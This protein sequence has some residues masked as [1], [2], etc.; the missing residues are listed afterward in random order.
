MPPQPAPWAPNGTG[1]D[2]PPRIGMS[3]AFRQ[4]RV[5]LGALRR[6]PYRSACF[7]LAFGVVAV[8]ALNMVAQVRL[9]TWQG[10]FYNA[11]DQR[12]ASELL[13]QTLIFL[14]IVAGLLLLVVGETFF[15][16]LLI[17]RLR[18]WLTRD[19]LD[20]WV[21]GR[22]P[23]LLSFRGDIAQNPDQRLQADAR[24]L[25]ELSIGLAIGLLRSSLLLVGFL[26]VLWTLSADTTFHLDGRE[27]RIPG[28]LVWCALAYAIGGSWL[29][30]RVGRPMIGLNAERY[31]REAELRFALVRVSENAEAIALD[32]GAPDER[33]FL[34]R[35]VDAVVA[36]TRR[37]AYALARLTWITSGYGWLGNI[38]PILAAAPSYFEGQL[39]FGG[40]MM[41]VGAFNQV[42]GALRWFVD[43][44]PAIADWR[45]T[46]F[47]VGGLRETLSG[48]EALTVGEGR[49]AH[50][51]NAARRIVLADLRVALP[52]GELALEEPLVELAPGE[53]ALL[54]SPKGVGVT[55][56]F[57]ALAGLWPW[58]S[59]TVSLP[60]PDRVVF[61][62]GHPYLPLGTLRAVLA[63]PSAPDAAGFG[64]ADLGAALE[65][66]GLGRLAPLL[67]TERRWDRE[68]ATDERQRLVAARLLLRRPIAVV[69]D[70]P[71][72][73]LDPDRRELLVDLFTH[74]LAATTVLALGPPIQDAFHQRRI[75]FQ[76]RPADGGASQGQ[77]ETA[78][79]SRG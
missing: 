16:E 59:G 24:H 48:L 50:V 15:R 33:R 69:M 35:P 62:P 60:P 32:G 13:H 38:V 41:S 31:A 46:L 73:A 18:E 49:I 21:T 27:L 25:T 66:A 75:A 10:D 28:Y 1:K 2:P 43:N 39:T 30:W 63:Y 51:E 22:R 78:A 55:T 64:D 40:L 74:E 3:D 53:R 67:D 12:Q 36:I 34:D 17:V 54:T 71:M 19:L 6:S 7:L 65:R 42:Q 61:L 56:V 8:I 76:H 26:G 68:L 14:V 70:E 47:R 45:A 57:R 79:E 5:L 29:T 11:I 37:L 20:Q 9:N 4:L 52:E 23:W 44:F 58:G 77:G 72:S